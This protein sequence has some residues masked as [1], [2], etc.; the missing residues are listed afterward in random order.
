[1]STT[2]ETGWAVLTGPSRALV[3]GNGD[4]APLSGFTP[5]GSVEKP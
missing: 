1:M 3:S 4:N 5:L 2:N